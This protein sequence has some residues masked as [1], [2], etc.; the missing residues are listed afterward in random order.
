MATPLPQPPLK[1]LLTDSTVFEWQKVTLRADLILV[2]A[3]ALCLSIGIAIGH[4]AA[5]MLAAGGAVNTGFGQKHS[6]DNSSLL[7]MLYVTLGMAFSGFFGVLIGH[8]NLLLVFMAALWGFGY[9]MLTNRPE[10]YGWVG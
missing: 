5:G 9:G 6:I 1:H 4:P 8:Q 3:V 2:V 7:P 10:G